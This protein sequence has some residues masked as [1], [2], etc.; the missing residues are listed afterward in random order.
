MCV[1]VSPGINELNQRCDSRALVSHF[2]FIISY[3]N[4]NPVLGVLGSW[5]QSGPQDDQHKV[6]I[7]V[8]ISSF[9]HPLK[10]YC[11]SFSLSLPM[12]IHIYIGQLTK[13]WLSCYLIVQNQVTRQ[14][15]FCGLTHIYIYIYI[16]ASK[17][18]VITGPGSSL[19]PV[20][21]E[22]N[23]LWR[24]KILSIPR[25]AFENVT[26]KCYP[27]ANKIKLKREYIPITYYFYW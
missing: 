4:H 14:S 26:E 11:L 24:K 16:Y 10:W 27:G 3:N 18:L 22:V 19:T 17:H 20:P 6:A 5:P 21:C 13:L 8:T 2:C 7:I 15:Q 23:D 1:C 25:N 9:V 12:Y